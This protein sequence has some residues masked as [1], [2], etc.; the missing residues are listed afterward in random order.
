MTFNVEDIARVTHE[1]NRAYCTAIGDDSQIPW[2]E[3]P[4]WQKESALA[5]VAAHLQNDMTPRA[6]HELWCKHKLADGW[7]WGITKDEKAKKH[8]CLVPYDSLPKE[9]RV[10]DYLFS[11]VVH[12]LKHLHSNAI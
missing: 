10:K 5:G 8:P 4:D 12:S 6:S 7:S 11:A 9:Q 3:A 2:D 1:V